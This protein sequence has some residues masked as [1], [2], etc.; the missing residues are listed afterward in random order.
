MSYAQQLFESKYLPHIKSIVMQKT[1][2]P[3]AC[4]NDIPDNWAEMLTYDRDTAEELAFHAKSFFSLTFS[5]DS[6]IA[7]DPETINELLGLIMTNMM[8]YLKLNPDF[9][10]NEHAAQLW[11]NKRLLRH[12]A[13]LYRA[14][15]RSE[16]TKQKRPRVVISHLVDEFNN[17]RRVMRVDIQNKTKNLK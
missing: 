1:H 17:T 2:K 4:Q 12:N 5:P 16:A 13:F 9:A 11:M 14:N 8:P 6:K 7:S 10:R 15:K 3:Y